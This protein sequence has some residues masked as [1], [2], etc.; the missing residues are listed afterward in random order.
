MQLCKKFNIKPVTCWGCSA[1][2]NTLEQSGC[3]GQV[4]YPSPLS[5]HQAHIQGL[6]QWIL[7]I[8][9]PTLQ[10]VARGMGHPDSAQTYSVSV[11]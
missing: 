10:V 6:P 8:V 5:A 11:Y 3:N 1:S 4:C 2:A 9:Y 7:R